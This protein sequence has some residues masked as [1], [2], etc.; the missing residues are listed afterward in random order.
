MEIVMTIITILVQETTI[1]DQTADTTIMKKDLTFTK[2][3]L[4]LVTLHLATWI[5]QITV[6]DGATEVQA[7]TLAIPDTGVKVLVEV[8]VQA[9]AE[10]TATIRD[11]KVKIGEEDDILTIGIIEDK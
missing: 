1:T 5:H 3:L 6:E 8:E 2:A 9:Q 10:R 7:S 11:M 4:T